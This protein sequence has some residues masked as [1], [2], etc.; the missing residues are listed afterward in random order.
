MAQGQA[1][2][3]RLA[4]RWQ[5]AAATLALATLLAHGKFPLWGFPLALAVAGGA[6]ELPYGAI[7]ALGSMAGAIWAGEPL[8]GLLCLGAPIGGA[9]GRLRLGLRRGYSGV[10]WAGLLGS[11]AA[12]FMAGGP[13]RYALIPITVLLALAVASAG[14]ALRGSS[15]DGRRLAAAVLA[16]WAVLSLGD[17]T[18]FGATVAPLAAI[19]FTLAAVRL[20]TAAVPFAVLLGVAMS[21][22]GQ[23]AP[24]FALGLAAGAALAV[25]VRRYGGFQAWLGLAVG[26]VML[27]GGMPIPFLEAVVATLLLLLG[28][29]LSLPEATY[30]ELRG[31]FS[32]QAVASPEP[33]GPPERLSEALAQ[34]DALVRELSR[35]QAPEI[36]EE[37]DVA[38]F[39][40]GVRERVCAGCPHEA[41]C[42]DSG[43]YATYT[44]VRDLM[45]RAD[46]A[47]ATSRDLP[48]DLRK[49]CPR[50]D[51]VATAVVL[52]GDRLRA[53]AN[54]RRH[55][56]AERT[57]T[58]DTL[59]GVRQMLGWALSEP[60]SPPPR[61]LSFSS[62]LARVAKNPGTVSG[63]N[64]VVRE[65]PDGRLLLGL[66]DGMG[67]G[68]EAAEQ[69]ASALDIVEGFLAAGMDP[70]V[71]LRA[72][73]AARRVSGKETFA[74]IDLA[75][76]DL[77]GGE[78]A[79]LKIGAPETYL[80]R[81]D[82]VQVLRGDALP[83]GILPEA[84]ATVQH[85]PLRAGDVLVLVSD[86]VLEGPPGPRGQWLEALLDT[87][88]ESDPQ[89]LAEAILDAAIGRRRDPR[90]DVT[91][92]VTAFHP[93][94]QEPEIRAWV[95][96]GRPELGIVGGRG[97]QTS[98]GRRR[99]PRG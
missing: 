8:L 16:I 96:R 66:S 79:S 41:V 46:A 86:G 91:V 60:S 59:I 7:A 67:T 22:G 17:L 50:P 89:Y 49:R 27:L 58:R 1:T 88:P 68:M 48:P 33:A 5:E 51:Q 45:L 9:L 87:L 93:A 70:V 56:H 55:L 81:A 11:A 76:A 57:L 54:V 74:T 71:A 6:A 85:L 24:P 21:L 72:A 65:L 4:V 2:A 36:A 63:D 39:L 31:Y 47:P 18:L 44:G 20:R 82:T 53:E 61:R 90:D 14:A 34:I 32:P 77:A 40:S 43:F 84:Q 95:R 19:L 3:R 13:D 42:W 10:L 94:A 28:V 25:Y 38:R 75:I 83:L 15:G 30:Q 99:R 12:Y 69:S 37:S 23:V 52:A 78:I 26:L 73:N 98:H 29:S 62:G 35:E 64:Y 92:L 80:R 97:G